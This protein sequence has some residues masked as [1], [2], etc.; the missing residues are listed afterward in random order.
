VAAHTLDELRARLLFNNTM[1]VWITLCRQ[2]GWRWRNPRG[3]AELIAHLRAR[4]V[5]L[6]TSKIRHPLQGLAPG[7]R[8]ENFTVRL[9]EETM[10]ALAEFKPTNP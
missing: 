2:Y 3:Y 4:G 7:Q 9:D 10:I 5:A 1:E 6:Q 8:V